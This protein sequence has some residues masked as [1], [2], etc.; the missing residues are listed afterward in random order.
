MNSSIVS[1]VIEDYKLELISESSIVDSF[2]KWISKV[3]LWFKKLWYKIKSFFSGN[4]NNEKIYRSTDKKEYILIKGFTPI[5]NICKLL[6]DKINNYESLISKLKNNEEIDIDESELNIDINKLNEYK[7]GIKILK[8]YP[9]RINIERL[10]YADNDKVYPVIEKICD[11]VSKLINNIIVELQ[12]IEKRDNDNEKCKKIITSIQKS[13]PTLV[14]VSKALGA[15]SNDLLKKEYLNEEPVSVDIEFKKPCKNKNIKLIRIMIKDYLMIAV[16]KP[17]IDI[18]VNYAE[19][20]LGTDLLYEKNVK[21][22][23]NVENMDR[24]KYN[25]NMVQLLY[26]FNKENLEAMIQ[27]TY[28]FYIVN[29]ISN[30]RGVKNDI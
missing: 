17:D 29:W 6:N 26:N 19:K 23:I 9:T 11:N 7:R 4:K 27:N 12:H 1:E 16:L 2:K 8:G 15:L 22:K 18:Y 24:D 13:I 3:I 21:V 5:S 10:K 28:N 14:T 20:E 30:T 25:Q